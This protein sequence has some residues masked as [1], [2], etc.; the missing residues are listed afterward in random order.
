[1]G[2][3]PG[4]FPSG[5]QFGSP[6]QHTF[7][8]RPR[9]LFSLHRECGFNLWIAP[10]SLAHVIEIHRGMSLCSAVA[11]PKVFFSCPPCIPH[12]AATSQC[13]GSGTMAKFMQQKQMPHQKYGMWISALPFSRYK[14]LP[15]VCHYLQIYL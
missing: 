13:S 15:T 7:S 11:W 14:S 4:G 2:Q 9:Q 6:R 8:L 10:T 3:H 1:M 12:P 5:K